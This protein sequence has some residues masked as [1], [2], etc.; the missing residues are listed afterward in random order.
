M[1]LTRITYNGRKVYKDKLS[2][3]TWNPGDTKLVT[4]KHA[5]KLLR[6]FE[7]DLPAENSAPTDAEVEVAMIVE[8]ESE[9]A[10]QDE[11]DLTESMLLTVESMDKP[12]LEE[13]ARK[14]EVELDRRRSLTNLRA[15]VANLV[16]QFGA[17]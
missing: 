9:R 12:A 5:R 14:Y 8:K 11:R 2:G 10:K 3:N 6:F 7:F 15:E 17:R 1:E 16:E 4:E 13:Y